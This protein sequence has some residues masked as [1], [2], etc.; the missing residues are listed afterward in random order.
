[1]TAPHSRPSNNPM[2]IW[3]EAL[4]KDFDKAFVG[5]DIL[6]GEIDS[7]QVGVSKSLFLFF[8]KQTIYLINLI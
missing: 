5:L 8:Y 4:E 2:L 3:L 6:L 7:D 1:M